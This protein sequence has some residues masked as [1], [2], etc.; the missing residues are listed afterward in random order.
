[1]TL[2]PLAMAEVVSIVEGVTRKIWHLPNSFPIVGLHASPEEL[3][4]K[5]S[6]IWKDYC[7]TTIRSWTENLNYGGAMGATARASLQ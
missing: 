4:L 7:S 1:M 3:G 2:P 6:T 5:N